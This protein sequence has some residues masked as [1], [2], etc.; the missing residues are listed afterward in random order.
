[1]LDPSYAFQPSAFAG[2]VQNVPGLT[3]FSG[4]PSAQGLLPSSQTLT[5][6]SFQAGDDVFFTKGRHLL[7]FG[8]QIERMQDN[9]L[10]LGSVN[11]S[12]RFASLLNFL[13]NRPQSFQ[14]N[15]TI[16]PPE[17]GLRQTVAG[18]YFEDDVRLR[19][20][21]TIDLGLRY[22]MATVIS[23]AHNRLSNLR[24]LTDAQPFVGSPF[25]LNPTL[26]NFERELDLP[27]S[28][29]GGHWGRIWHVRVLPLPYEFA[30]SVST[31]AVRSGIFETSFLRLIPRGAYN[32]LAGSGNRLVR[33]TEHAPK[34]NYVMQWNSSVARELSS[35]GNN[36]RLC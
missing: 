10:I 12:F 9:Q 30:I 33:S 13:T 14:G 18:A 4:A 36:G 26:R 19:S 25:Y 3:S 1:M 21:L 34:R 15:E 16:A 28:S 29:R 20:T 11:G 2:S 31:D 5:W 24:N 32:L 23:E 27:E 17:F 7:K 22:E 6:N 8:G 35:P